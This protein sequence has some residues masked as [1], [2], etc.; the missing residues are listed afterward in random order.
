M[1]A[2]ILS[3]KF[4][5]Q[6]VWLIFCYLWGVETLLTLLGY[7]ISFVCTAGAVVFLFFALV[8]VISLLVAF[9]MAI[10]EDLRT[11]FGRK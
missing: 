2:V 5:I 4:N 8:V 10:M 3:T 6:L 1:G 9:P 7:L 11:F